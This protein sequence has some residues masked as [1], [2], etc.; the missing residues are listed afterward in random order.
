[1]ESIDDL[2]AQLAATEDEAEQ[3]G[4]F[5]AI[6]IQLTLQKQPLE[7]LEYSSRALD[8]RARLADR[9]VKAE[10]PLASSLFNRA[11]HLRVLKRYDEAAASY[12]LAL[13]VYERHPAESD[14]RYARN[15]EGLAAVLAELRCHDMAARFQGAAIRALLEA[16]SD[17]REVNGALATLAAYL[18][19]LDNDVPTR[20]L[21]LSTDNGL[22]A[23]RTAALA[24]AQQLDQ[25]ATRNHLEGRFAEAIVWATRTVRYCDLFAAE[26]DSFAALSTENLRRVA[27]WS[28]TAQVETG[29]AGLAR[30]KD[31]LTLQQS[32][33]EH[34]MTSASDA[35]STAQPRSLDRRLSCCSIRDFLLVVED[36]KRAGIPSSDVHT[37]A[38]RLREKRIYPA[39]DYRH[40]CQPRPPDIFITYD[41]RQDFVGLYDMIE[42]ALVYMGQ[43]VH[44]ARPDLDSTRIRHLVFD[45]IGLW[46]DFVFIDQSARD[47]GAEVREIIPR[48]IDSSDLHFVLSDTAL[49]RSWC[50]YELALFNRR[51]VAPSWQHEIGGH[52][53]RPLLSFVTQEQAHGFGGFGQTATTVL[54]DKEVIEKYLRE[55][56]PEGLAGVDL[57]L[58]QAGFL[59]KRVTPGFAVPPAA[60]ERMLSAVDKWLAR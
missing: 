51:P 25:R 15:A 39:R 33:A 6:G 50:C 32:D 42:G 44:R 2:R 13:K 12:A 18:D 14:D 55:E 21:L 24:T 43:A 40:R 60:E 11:G 10:L 59:D 48:V 53:A 26:D 36:L 38:R 35:P 49:L 8:I 22:L 4:L 54:E 20:R 1:M 27:V 17:V 9:D 16:G 31:V 29:L 34:A 28:A 56:F 45:E 23:L 5:D 57:L 46:I 7:A 58:L 41:W 3:A 52:L 30:L 47:V 19:F 37:L